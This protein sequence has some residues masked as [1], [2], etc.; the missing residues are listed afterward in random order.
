MSAA[1]ATIPPCSATPS[2]RRRARTT[3]WTASAPPPSTA[4]AGSS[5][6]STGA[7]RTASRTRHGCTRSRRGGTGWPGTSSP[8]GCPPARPGGR[9]G[10][11]RR[12][13]LAGAAGEDWII[14][15]YA[16]EIR[17]AASRARGWSRD[18]AA[19]LLLGAAEVTTDY[20]LA[21]ALDVA[22]RAVEQLEPA[23]LYELAPWLRHV[24]GTFARADIPIGY[25]GPL[26]KRLWGLMETV[27]EAIL[28]DGLMPVSERWAAPLRASAATAP[29]LERARFVRHLVSLFVGVTSIAADAEWTD[30]GEDRFA[31]YWRETTFGEL[32]A[33][34]EVRRA[35]LARALPRTKIAGRCSLDGRYLVVR[36]ELRTYKIHLGSANIL[37]EPDD[38][39]LCIVQA[40]G[41]S[42]GTVYLPFED[43]RLSL[44]LSKAF[45]LA[46]DHKITDESIRAQIKRGA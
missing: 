12:P 30:R 34:A 43:E 14:W 41:R 42:M 22:L 33:S 37:M 28:P 29:A 20:R 32:S 9:P 17:G 10:V 5:T 31:A 44:I 45:L 39:Y 23:D 40:R 24:S 8:G 38:S 19:V 15:H 21:E 26:A 4:P 1:P 13:R 18:E 7:G 46:A 36:G 16:S 3:A 25:R 11:P 2:G 27:D 35:A 6:S